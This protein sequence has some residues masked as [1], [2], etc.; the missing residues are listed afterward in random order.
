MEQEFSFPLRIG[1]I[2]QLIPHRSP[3]LLIDTVTGFEKAKWI[4]GTKNVTA[5]ESFFAGHFPGRPV[6][7]GVLMV[8]AL[9]QLGA[10]FARVSRPEAGNKLIVF[11]GIE[12]CR[13]RRIVLP[14]DV[15]QLRMALIRAKF[16]TWK[17]EGTA[18]VGDE[19]AVEGILMASELPGT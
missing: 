11:S 9:A 19:I 16:G 14:G 10:L 12:S 1:D 17:M 8:E 3:F 15:L 6:M 13:F 2:E 4:E 7:P 18:K 5:N